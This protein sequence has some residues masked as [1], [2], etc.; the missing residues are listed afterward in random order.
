M[1]L[2]LRVRNLAME[3]KCPDIARFRADFTFCRV[4]KQ[5]AAQ[6]SLNREFSLSVDCSQAANYPNSGGTSSQRQLESSS[7][8]SCSARHLLLISAGRRELSSHCGGFDFTMR[9]P[10][11]EVPC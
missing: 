1:W 4:E 3:A 11:H 9:A 6:P 2:C 5:I 7:R 10:A 8:T